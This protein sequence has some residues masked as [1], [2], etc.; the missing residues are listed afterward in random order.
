[1][2]QF[3]CG[4]PRQ[5]AER[6]ACQH[7]KKNDRGRAIFGWLRKTICVFDEAVIQPHTHS[8]RVLMPEERF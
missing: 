2:L 8:G 3:S 5:A 6:F 4:K 7:V 1:L